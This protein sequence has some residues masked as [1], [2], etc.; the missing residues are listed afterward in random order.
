[1][2]SSHPPRPAAGAALLLLTALALA[3]PASQAAAAP[4]APME[5]LAEAA[6]FAIR[7]QDT[8]QALALITLGIDVHRTLVG[9]GTLL[10]PLLK[11]LLRRGLPM[12]DDA[13]LQAVKAAAAADADSLAIAARLL[14]TVPPRHLQARDDM[15]QSTAHVAAARRERLPLVE[16]EDETL[17]DHARTS[18]VIDRLER[19]MSRHSTLRRAPPPRQV[20]HGPHAS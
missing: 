10:K 17:V 18:R 16:H 3:A 7:H 6:S 9:G 1:M 14:K 5:E 13:P 8:A 11:P 15:G 4:K 19:E 20:K 2:A 12:P